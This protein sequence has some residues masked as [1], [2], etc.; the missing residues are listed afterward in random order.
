[1]LS[2]R[3]VSPDQSCR[4]IQA[5]IT[6][7][8]GSQ[9]DDC[10]C[11]PST[12]ASARRFSRYLGL[13]SSTPGSVAMLRTLL[14]LPTSTSAHT[15][16]RSDSFATKAS[17]VRK[18]YPRQPHDYAGKWVSPKSNSKASSDTV[19]S[20][21]N[22]LGLRAVDR[23]KS[24]AVSRAIGATAVRA[25]ARVVVDGLIVGGAGTAVGLALLPLAVRFVGSGID[26]VTVTGAAVVFA[27]G[28]GALISL[29]AALVPALW[30]LKMP[31][32]KALREQLSPPVWTPQKPI[33]RATQRDEAAIRA[34]RGECWPEVKKSRIRG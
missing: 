32:Y 3:P 15:R 27:G 6:S 4:S 14:P 12:A 18:T 17:R 31:I 10:C 5:S 19:G 25:A 1:M 20:L 21:A 26:G 8:C 7:A 11:R 2:G 24:L 22:A 13:L 33:T 34:W 28:C 9:A 29:V 30:T 23:A 16:S